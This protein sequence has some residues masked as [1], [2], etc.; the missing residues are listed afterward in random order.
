MFEFAGNVSAAD[1][2]DEDY[3]DCAYGEI[4]GEVVEAF[5]EEEVFVGGEVGVGA[6]DGYELGV[7]NADE[8]V[9][10]I[11][12]HAFEAENCGSVGFVCDVV[13]VVGNCEVE[14]GEGDKEEDSE[15]QAVEGDEKP[16]AYEAGEGDGED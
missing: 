14:Y 10:K 8:S 4:P 6:E 1:S 11:Q 3:E 13:E 15:D 9:S 12:C 5:F 2:G 16:D 7:E